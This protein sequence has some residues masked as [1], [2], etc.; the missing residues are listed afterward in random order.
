MNS[1]GETSACANTNESADLNFAVQWYDT[2]FG[3]AAHDD[4]ATG[5][6]DALK[7]K[8]LQGSDDDGS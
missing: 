2:A 6:A 4:V 1:S 3:A 5:L 8:S 7:T